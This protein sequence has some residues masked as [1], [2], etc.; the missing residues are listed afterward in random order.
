MYSIYGRQANF[1][2]FATSSA[3]LLICMQH[4]GKP[5]EGKKN[6]YFQGLFL[7]GDS[8]IPVSEWA[9]DPSLDASAPGWAGEKL[10]S[11]KDK[12]HGRRSA[13]K[14]RKVYFKQM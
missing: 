2:L 1:M 9:L 6:I 12:Y 10:T 7:F 14:G 13:M 4:E 3:K 5:L 11:G 8:K